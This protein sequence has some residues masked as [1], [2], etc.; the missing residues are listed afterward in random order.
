[1]PGIREA[2]RAG[3]RL[4]VGSILGCLLSLHVL[5]V[6]DSGYR[7]ERSRGE[8]RRQLLLE[9]GEAKTERRTVK[10]EATQGKGQDLGQGLRGDEEGAVT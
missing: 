8:A 6:F 5:C 7:D 9:R 2:T 1:M 4:C 3:R 10:V